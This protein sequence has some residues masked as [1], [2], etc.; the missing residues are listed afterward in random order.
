MRLAGVNFLGWKN[1]TL[2]DSF[3]MKA[4][5]VLEIRARGGR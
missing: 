4:G 1:G 2:P 3:A 5:N